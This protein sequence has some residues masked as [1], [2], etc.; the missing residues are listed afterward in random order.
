[1]KDG[2]VTIIFKDNGIGIDEKLQEKVFERF[3]RAQGGS[4]HDVKGF[5]LGLSYARSVIE[6]HGGRISLQSRKGSGSEFII[7]LKII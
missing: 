1:V 5:G 6:A 3:Y 2:E 7:T 4:L